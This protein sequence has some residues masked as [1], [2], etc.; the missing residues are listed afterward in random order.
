MNTNQSF[1]HKPQWLQE[2]ENNSWNPELLI[3]AIS[4]VFVFSISDEINDFG[5]LL[6]QR[7]GLQPYMIYFIL[8]Y[9]NYAIISLKLS[10]G[11]HLF[12]RGVWIGLVGL[13]FTFPKGI[14]TEKLSKIQRQPFLI[15][16]YGNPVEGILRLE[17]ICSSIFGL[18]F[19]IVGLSIALLFILGFILFLNVLGV[20]LGWG[21]ISVFGLFVT[22]SSS[23]VLYYR[24]EKWFGL[25]L[26][27][28]Q[29]MAVGLMRLYRPLFF[30][31]SIML[32]SSNLNRYFV[33]TLFVLYTMLLGFFG[34]GQSDR[35]IGF[36]KEIQP[37]DGVLQ[38]IRNKNKRPQ[39]KQAI[40]NYYHDQ[41]ESYEQI[42]KACIQS[43]HVESPFI[44]IFLPKF[45]WDNGILDSLEVQY[46]DR[47]HEAMVD[48]FVRVRIDGHLLDTIIW[49]N[50]EQ[51]KTGQFGW[52]TRVSSL[53]LDAGQHIMTIER[54]FWD[55]EKKKYYT[56]ET[57]SEIPFWT[58]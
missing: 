27:W 36:L 1:P 26:T 15:G 46:P 7:Y 5:I 39:S 55:F 8:L 22:F 3:S 10:F 33:V 21:A 47:A 9:V 48:Q 57:W 6:V 42:Q 13:N 20:P 45:E 37:K 25:K 38:S 44:E 14:D 31:Q 32:F 40:T 49:L 43:L 12:L 29:R 34:A 53:D 19:T 51:P 50:Y 17:R 23:A 58:N 30:Q 18:A 16:E 52:I 54:S 28:L 41:L 2:I 11:L 35:F 4:I 24:M 56:A